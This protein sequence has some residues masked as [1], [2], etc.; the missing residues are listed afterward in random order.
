VEG[1]RVPSNNPDVRGSHKVRKRKERGLEGTFR[2]R[3]LLG[4]GEEDLE[5]EGR[6]S[7]Q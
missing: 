4:K 2:K 1:R 6:R 5:Q 7:G 3:R